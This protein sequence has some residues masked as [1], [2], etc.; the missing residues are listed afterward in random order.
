[1][2]SYSLAYWLAPS[3]SGGGRAKT[4]LRLGLTLLLLLL[5]VV[6]MLTALQ[7]VPVKRRLS[8]SSTLPPATLIAF[9]RYSGERCGV[10]AWKPTAGACRQW[11]KGPSCRVDRQLAI[12]G[13]V[14]VK[15]VDGK[16]LIRHR[17]RR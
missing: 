6:G 10:R 5:L 7:L 8:F 1:M 17:S 11:T 4:R 12:T 3:Y 14:A 13:S 9:S 2:A 15:V 16:C